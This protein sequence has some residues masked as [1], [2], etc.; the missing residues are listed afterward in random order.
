MQSGEIRLAVYGMKYFQVFDLPPVSQEQCSIRIS[1]ELF[2]IPEDITLHLEALDGEWCFPESR[3]YSIHWK[4]EVFFLHKVHENEI[5]MLTSKRGSRLLMIAQRKGDTIPVYRKFSLDKNQTVTI[6]SGPDNTIQFQRAGLVSRH[7]GRLKK[8]DRWIYEDLGS[9]NGSFYNHRQLRGSWIALEPGDE[10][11]IYGL[12]MIF[13]GDI[14]AVS[15]TQEAVYGEELKLADSERIKWLSSLQLYAEEEE[16]NDGYF[17]RPT[18]VLPEYE[19]EPVEIEAPPA[20]KNQ[21]ER[22]LLM[23]IGPS[24]T[25]AI[26]MLVGVIITGM[27]GLVIGLITMLGSAAIGAFWAWMNMN[28]QKKKAVAEEEQRFQAYS[29]YLQKKEAE[30][31]EKTSRNLEEMI[32][33]YPDGGRCTTFGTDSGRLWNRNDTQSDFLFFRLGTGECDQQMD[34]RIPRERFTLIRDT[35]AEEPARIRDT[36]QVLKGAPVGVDLEGC[37]ILGITGG[38]KKAGIYSVLRTLL[39]QVTSSC[40]YTDVKMVFL[41]DGNSPEQRELLETVKWFPHLWDEE[42]NIRYAADGPES[43]AGLLLGISQMIRT[44]QSRQSRGGQE[45]APLPLYLIF[46]LDRKLLENTPPEEALLDNGEY[47]GITTIVC[48]ERR[49][50]LPNACGIYIQN[51]GTETAIVSSEEGMRKVQPLRLDTVSPHQLGQYAHT[52]AAVQVRPMGQNA[53]IPD[54]VTFFEMYGVHTPGE[55]QVEERWKNSRVYESMKVPFGVR[56][57][58]SLCYLDIHDGSE[59]GAEGDG[60][61]GLVAGTTGSGKSE[62]L[63]T[64]LLALAVNF[65]PEDLSFFIIDYKGGGMADLFTRLPHMQGQISNLSGSEIDRA[66]ISLKSE[67]NRRQ[68]VF[69]ENG[70]TKIDTYIRRYKNREIRQPMPH[71]VL[72]IDEFA[73]LKKERPEFMKEVIHIATIGRSLGVHLI[74]STQKPGG[75]VDDNISS[76]MKFRLCLKVE[77][78]QDSMDM[79][80]KDDAVYIRQTGRGYLKVGEGGT[81][82]LF[83]SAWSGAVYDKDMD[84]DSTELA[85]M[86]RLTGET[87]LVGNHQRMKQ[88]K[89]RKKEW[90]ETLW[91]ILERILME[92]ETSLENCLGSTGKGEEICQA[93]YQ[94]LWSQGTDYPQSEANTGKIWNFLEACYECGAR[95]GE[96]DG[97]KLA[98]ML[99]DRAEITGRKYPESREKTQLDAVVDYIADM[100]VSQEMKVQHRLWLPVLPQTIPLQTIPRYQQ[101]EFAGEWRTR[102]GEDWSLEAVVGMYDDPENQ[103]QAPVV[104]NL[105][106][107]GHYAVC[108]TVGSGKSTFLQTLVYSLITRYSPQMLHVYGVDFSSHMLG[109]FEGDAHTGDIIYENQPEKLARFFY[110]MKRILNERKAILRGGTFTQYIR[111][112]GPVL[113]AIVIVLDQYG[114]FREKTDNKYQAAILELVKEG[115]A[116]G[117]YLVI[118]ANAYGTSELPAAITDNIRGAVCLAMNDKYQYADVL[119]SGRV[120]ILPDTRYKG[121][122]LLTVFGRMLEFQTAV[123][124]KAEDDYRRLELIQKKCRDMSEAWD[125]ERAPAVPEVPEEPVYSEFSQLPKVKNLLADDRM[126]PIGYHMASGEVAALDMSRF[127]CYLIMG[128][129]R[130]GKTNFLQTVIRMAGEKGGRLSVIDGSGL[131]ER[132][133]RE[134]RAA[135]LKTPEEIL[136]YFH[137]L[138]P[139]IQK[140]NQKKAALAAEGMD[141]AE[142]YEEMK[143]E[144]AIFIFIQD[145]EAFLDIL[146]EPGEGKPNMAGFFEMLANKGRMHR[147]YM[148]AEYQGEGG[149][150][151]RSREFFRAFVKD[152]EGILFGG[153]ASD[154]DILDFD[155][156]GSLA[157]KSRAERRGTGWLAAGENPALT[158]RVKIPLA[159]K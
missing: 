103:R 135:Y 45:K 57:G 17:N 70:V 149:Y 152:G 93:F 76:N 2:Q 95:K 20:P 89:Q 110:M 75:V 68:A 97:E 3:E 130:T 36:Y 78:R 13:L 67:L 30:I 137:G 48:T 136:E 117:M 116:C 51:E 126:L 151:S 102:A 99:L 118:S 77:S 22:S 52:L 12:R 100:P 47:L 143:A 54:T 66:L 108:G 39:A 113:P 69:R 43:A 104:L 34:I 32:R 120:N 153:G 72:V 41:C 11:E 128:K 125:G 155:Y 119:K 9:A 90:L 145:M 29:E 112:N 50:E 21:G 101:E 98:E 46:V 115:A 134:S 10:I 53:K 59:A 85:R 146:Y 7:H 58:G 87:I 37:R 96:T 38:E 28:A 83:Q 5:L 82:E 88:K 31:K 74:L 55:L 141:E 62:T 148:F 71:L 107:N 105:A 65:S 129:R 157:Q 114:S 131:L 6:G 8:T 86:Y 63:Q 142:I 56:E 1:G 14:L 122:G 49:E 27:G 156:M 123:A 40:S 18:R 26:P 147:I 92:Q 150:G 79:L 109:A 154:Q 138:M 132:T 121:R 44:R 139:E 140:R 73:E 80:R 24:I 133:A 15:A 106:E 91:K 144:E 94:A 25:M 42:K 84:N 23:T 159:G 16:R 60:P 111:A 61:H 19:T 158:G 64:L 124:V 4:N 127:Y 35:L 81:Y 33:Q